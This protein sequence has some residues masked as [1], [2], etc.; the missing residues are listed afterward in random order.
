MTVAYCCGVDLDSLYSAK[1]MRLQIQLDR[2]MNCRPRAII[3]EPIRDGA[4][5]V[6]CG[7]VHTKHTYKVRGVSP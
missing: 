6:G 1:L 3:R 7:C 5:T 2:P 4:K